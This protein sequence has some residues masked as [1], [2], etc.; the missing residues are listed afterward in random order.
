L[1][2]RGFGGAICT[3]F[4][5]ACAFLAVK[6]YE[7]IKSHIGL[8]GAFWIYSGVSIVGLFFIYCAVPETKGVELEEMHHMDTTVVSLGIGHAEENAQPQ[9]QPSPSHAPCSEDLNLNAPPPQNP[10]P[11]PRSILKERLKD[12]PPLLNNNHPTANNSQLIG[13]RNHYNSN[14]NSL[15]FQP[16]PRSILKEYQLVSGRPNPSDFYPEDYELEIPYRDSYSYQPHYNPYYHLNQ[17]TPYLCTGAPHTPHH[18]RPPQYH[19]HHHH[20]KYGQ[21]GHNEILNYGGL[22]YHPLQK[23]Q[24]KGTSVWRS[25]ISFELSVPENQVLI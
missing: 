10:A 19:H 13:N 24:L 15:Q 11:S 1:I 7:D 12:S 17:F 21:E 23:R 2:Y 16:E 20:H 3:S 4:S 6:T 25:S 14:R 8:Y 18:Y 9:P 5:Y 22:Y